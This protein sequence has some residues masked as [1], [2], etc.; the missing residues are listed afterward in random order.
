MGTSLVDE[1]IYAKSLHY[2]CT[3]QVCGLR[4]RKEKNCREKQAERQEKK[5][6]WW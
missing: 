6:K 1:K 2:K 4:L 5:L 3:S